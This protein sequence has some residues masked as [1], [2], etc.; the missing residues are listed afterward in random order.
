MAD[1]TDRVQASEE[2]QRKDAIA[3]HKTRQA[4]KII[5]DNG[6]DECEDCGKDISARRKIRPAN[7][8]ASCQAKTKCKLADS[9]AV[10]YLG[11]QTE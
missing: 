7:R 10:G 11:D 5:I 9:S 1:L 8:C 2:V 3:R 6:S 4:A